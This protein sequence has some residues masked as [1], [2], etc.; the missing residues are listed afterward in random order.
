MK[1]IS[2]RLS[3]PASFRLHVLD[4]YYKYSWEDGDAFDVPKSTLYDWKRM[5]QMSGKKPVSLV[6]KST[7]PH[8]TRKMTTDYRLIEFI[9]AMREE[10]GNVGSGIIKLFLDGYAKVL[11][12]NSVYRST[13]EKV[14]KRRRLTFEKRVKYNRKSKYS[15]LR[16]KRSPRVTKPGYVQMDSIILYVNRG[17]H[18]FMSMIDMYTKYALVVK[19]NTLSSVMYVSYTCSLI[20]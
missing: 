10:Y 20:F 11:G 1:L 19:V 15:R 6:P 9:K 17:K 16:V 12:I 14:I 13:I 3:D 4:H 7:R 5:F 8:H 2:P 18:M